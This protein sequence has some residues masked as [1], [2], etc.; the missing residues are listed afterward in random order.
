MSPQRPPAHPPPDAPPDDDTLMATQRPVLIAGG[1]IGGLST[2]I[3]LARTGFDS[4]V[5]ERSTF[6]EESGAGIQLGPNATRI[7][8]E[9][10][11]LDAIAPCAFKPEAIKLFDGL[12]GK[13]IASVPL[14]RQVETRYG[15][16]YLTVHR[17]DLHGALHA[18]AKDLAPVTLTPGFDFERVEA[19]G[20]GV[21]AVSTDGVT[22]EGKCLIG[23]DGLW[24]SVRKSIAPDAA[25]SFAGAT[26]FRTLLPRE[27]LSAPF[28]GPNVGLWLG[29]HAHMVHYPVRG[30]DVLN[31][32]AVI[33][34]RREAYGWNQSADLG[35]LRAG[36]IRWC[37]KS[38]SL[39]ERGESWRAWSLFSLPPLR[40]WSDGLVALLGDAAHPVLPYLAQGAGLAIEDAWCLAHC[41]AADRKQPAIAFG[42]YE[43][44]RCARGAQ[45]QRSA[46]RMGWIYHGRGPVRLVRNFVLQRSKSNSLLRQF[47]WLY[48]R[49]APGW[50]N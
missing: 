30:G 25:L 45:L 39:L 38:K 22:I 47:D 13:V 26:A 16:P 19:D 43:T 7:L 35:A 50:T 21:T 2:A 4:N 12:S 9:L 32:V 20:D 15:A 40:Q 23:A 37:E 3:A 5:L 6:T 49:N 46:R 1:G 14:G 29:P 33:G 28:D 42:A 18:V 10:G 8:A 24:S 44:T 27:A 34:D 36:F 48:G 41:L 11:A 17:A 31:V